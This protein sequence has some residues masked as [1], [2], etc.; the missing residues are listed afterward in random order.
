M[1]ESGVPR[2]IARFERWRS[3]LVKAALAVEGSTA[4][5]HFVFCFFDR[6]VAI[7]QLLDVFSGGSV[8]IESVTLS[9]GATW[10]DYCLEQSE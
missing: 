9:K 4:A 2:L 3:D 6:C 7:V 8:C 5:L 1:L 10:C